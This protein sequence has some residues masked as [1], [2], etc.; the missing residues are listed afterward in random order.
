MQM[1]NIKLKSYIVKLYYRYFWHYKEWQKSNALQ[2]QKVAGFYCS[3]TQ[4][5]LVPKEKQLVIFMVDGRAYHG[6]L[7]D[8]LKGIVA[9][10]QWCLKHGY[11]FRICWNYPYKLDDYLLPNKY[12]WM[13]DK[14]DLIYN[15]YAKP[16]TLYDHGLGY[17]KL[18]FNICLHKEIDAYHKQYH[19]YSNMC[20]Y[21]SYFFSAF[22]KLF[23]PVNK[24]QV[25][26]EEHLNNIGK[27]YVSMTFRFQEL[28]GDFREQGQW[29]HL[30]KTEADSLINK[31]ISKIEEIYNR[32]VKTGRVLVTSDSKTFLDEVAK[33]LNFAYVIPGNLCHMDY[34]NGVTDYDTHMR[35]FLDMYM[36]SN[37]KMVYLLIADDMYHSN[38]AKRSSLLGRCHY[39]EIVF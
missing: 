19:V 14:S 37:A 1:S 15:E 18:F 20:G 29:K 30:S 24:L 32:E 26:I 10:Y 36:I 6:G 23:R 3:H 11:D 21:D 2:Y 7:S 28:L 25:T 33:R 27:D 16:I 4:S 9:T 39:K 8:R 22:H 31:C 34:N 5:T 38:F 17:Q 12:N 13:I 35:S